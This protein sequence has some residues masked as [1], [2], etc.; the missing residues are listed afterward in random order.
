A[1]PDLEEELVDRFGDLPEAVQ[2]LLAVAKVKLMAGS[3]KVKKISLLSGQLRLLFGLEHTLTGEVL[4]E[5]SRRYKNYIKFNNTE[6]GFEVK[7]KL[8]RV[9][10]SNSGLF[11]LSQLEKLV[12][13]L[14]GS[15]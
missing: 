8:S 14:G 7:L 6:D 4:V 11:L 5:A 3:L 12:K 1:L 15:C 13:V 10:H 9:K 2:N